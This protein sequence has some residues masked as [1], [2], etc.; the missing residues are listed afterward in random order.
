MVQI[1]YQTEDGV[2]KVESK[3]EE[4]EY[5]SQKN[6]WAVLD[7]DGV[8]IIPQERVY[9]VIIGEDNTEFFNDESSKAIVHTDF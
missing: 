6:Q 3:P 9:E 7:A 5:S 4:I 8:H 1:K 2:Q